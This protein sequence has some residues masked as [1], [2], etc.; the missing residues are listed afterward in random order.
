MF[1]KDLKCLVLFQFHSSGRVNKGR[2]WQSCFCGKRSE[3]EGHPFLPGGLG[4][5]GSRPVPNKSSFYWPPAI[6]APRH[7]SDFKALCLSE[8]VRHPMCKAT[9]WLPTL[10]WPLSALDQG[11]L[12]VSHRALSSPSLLLSTIHLQQNLPGQTLYLSGIMFMGMSG[13][14]TNIISWIL[15]APLL[16]G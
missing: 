16:M 9:T 8:D 10:V 12:G 2:C 1:K 4:W 14:L 6:S 13:S 3:G 5:A 11:R 15:T 7:R